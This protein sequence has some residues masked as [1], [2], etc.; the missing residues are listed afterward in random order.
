MSDTAVDILD[1]VAAVQEGDYETLKTVLSN[2]I[3]SANSKDESGCTLL[4][5]AAI[6]NRITIAKLLIEYGANSMGGGLLNESPLQ[7]ALRKRFYAM[8]ELLVEKLHVDLRHKSA[9]GLDALHLCCRLGKISDPLSDASDLATEDLQGIY[10]L[11]YWGANPDTVDNDGNTPLLWL[12]KS[13]YTAE[14][15]A[16]MCLLV[17]FGA[18]VLAQDNGSLEGIFHVFAKKKSVNLS[19]AFFLF[20][21]GASNIPSLTN[22]SGRTPLA[23]SVFL[24]DLSHFKSF[25]GI[26]P[27]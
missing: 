26:N 10:L 20:Q 11:L 12:V 18:S 2:R 9:Q 8:A 21:Q 17:K 13:E 23:V 24:P 3:V 22:S 14:K 19:I 27:C 4:H 15:A 16:M 5:W 25:L 1:T 6:N 7:W